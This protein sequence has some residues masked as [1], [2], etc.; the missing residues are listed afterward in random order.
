MVLM[1]AGDYEV[2]TTYS[3]FVLAS[4]G[5]QDFETAWAQNSDVLECRANEC[6]LRST[7]SDHYA[8]VRIE[9]WTDPPPHTDARWLVAE[10]QVGVIDTAPRNETRE[11][12]LRVYQNMGDT[13]LSDIGEIP[14]PEVASMNIRAWVLRDPVEQWPDFDDGAR[15]LEDWLIRLWPT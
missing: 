12:G 1:F 6:L 13:D 11:Y 7:D 9:I 8:A 3:S 5:V 15:G 10:T 14:L 4:N 2:M